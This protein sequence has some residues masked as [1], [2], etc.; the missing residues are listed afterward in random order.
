VTTIPWVQWYAADFLNGVVELEVEEIGVYAV[1]LCLIYDSGGP[2]KD[3]PGRLARRCRKRLPQ[4]EALLDRLVAL[5]KIER[6]NGL[7]SNRRCANE[8][9][10]RR[11][12]IDKAR[13][14]ANVRWKKETKNLN[15][16]NEEKMPAQSG[17]MLDA[18][19]YQSQTQSKKKETP[20]R[21]VKKD[22][23]LP[24]RSQ[25]PKDFE[26]TAERKAVA[27]RWNIPYLLVAGEF[28]RFC[29]HHGS[30]GTVFLDWD[31]AWVTWCSKVMKFAETGGLFAP[32]TPPA[33]A[34]QDSEALWAS[35]LAV[36]QRGGWQIGWGPEPGE[37]DCRIPPAFVAK[38]KARKAA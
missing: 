26:L 33:S 29:S 25:L 11:E 6:S 5:G 32:P 4:L 13:D 17:R 2:I 21:G 3:E 31:K 36:H 37:P 14:H 8:L 12:K 34:P 24:R 20:L 35:Q 7:I 27:A 9:Q 1:I 18:D 15:D 16:N 10:K 19:A 23:P 28:E 22:A 38:W 30:K